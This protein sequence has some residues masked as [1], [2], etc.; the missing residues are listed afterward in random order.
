L[1]DLLTEVRALRADLNQTSSVST[2]ALLLAAR[3]QVQEHRIAEA[4]RQLAE[5]QRE[6]DMVTRRRE[7]MT[8]ALRAQEDRR[9]TLPA[10]QRTELDEQIRASVE[11]LQAETQRESAL[12][13]RQMDAATTLLS[14]QNRWSDFNSRL[15]E[16]ERALTR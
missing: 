5:L 13:Q 16:L 7:G 1:D 9:S 12:R 2:R 8:D 10:P 15:D 6:T 11:R 3:V 14:E 4:N